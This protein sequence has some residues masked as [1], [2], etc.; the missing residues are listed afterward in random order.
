MPA[1][2]A[3]RVVTSPCQ[4][5]TD[6]GILKATAE[7]I[8]DALAR[9]TALLTANAVLEEQVAQFRKRLGTIESRLHEVELEIAHSQ[10][11][12]RWIERV[13]WAVVTLSLAA[14]LVTT[15]Q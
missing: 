7:E 6:I 8:K 4:Y 1:G 5:E 15:K 3:G 11:S 13:V 2:I 14:L 9:L 12:S 10:G